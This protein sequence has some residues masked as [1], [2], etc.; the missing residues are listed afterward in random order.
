MNF[1]DVDNSEILRV[2]YKFAKCFVDNSYRV[3][4]LFG[5]EKI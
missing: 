2:V 5:L 1:R 3:I 4:F